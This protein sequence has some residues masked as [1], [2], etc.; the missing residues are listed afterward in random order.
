[1]YFFFTVRQR[2]MQ[3]AESGMARRRPRIDFST[4][5]QKMKEKITPA[6]PSPVRFPCMSGVIA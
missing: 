4:E 2:T 5:L 3:N 1:M 6:K